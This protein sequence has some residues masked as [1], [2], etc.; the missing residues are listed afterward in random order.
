MSGSRKWLEY[1]DTFEA[2]E[3]DEL[4][5]GLPGQV[6]DQILWRGRGGER[7]SAALQR[8]SMIPTSLFERWLAL[9]EAVPELGIATGLLLSATSSARTRQGW[10]DVNEAPNLAASCG[11]PPGA[12]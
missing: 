12:G 1:E 2:N 8:A 7:I 3:I 5:M 10:A 4:D 6:D 9:I 11:S